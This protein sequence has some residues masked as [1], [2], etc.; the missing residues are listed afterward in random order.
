MSQIK[1][2]QRSLGKSRE[3][4]DGGY[5]GWAEREKLKEVSAWQRVTNR[6]KGMENT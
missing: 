1:G 4:P 6:R 5:V 3:E 2:V